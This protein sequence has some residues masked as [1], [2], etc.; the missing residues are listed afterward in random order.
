MLS[1]SSRMCDSRRSDSM[2]GCLQAKRS[3]RRTGKFRK[4]LSMHTSIF[5]L[6]FT[7]FRSIGSR[8]WARPGLHHAI[9]P[10][11]TTVV[12]IRCI[13]FRLISIPQLEIV[14]S[15]LIGNTDRCKSFV[16]KENE[17]LETLSK[18]NFLSFQDSLRS[19]TW[20]VCTYKLCN[21]MLR[22]GCILKP[23]VKC[24]YHILPL[25][26][27]W[28]GSHWWRQRTLADIPFKL[29]LMIDFFLRK[30]T[31]SSTPGLSHGHGSIC[32]IAFNWLSTWSSGFQF[33]SQIDNYSTSSP[34]L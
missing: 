1:I 15:R 34:I 11:W 13:E 17:L 29:S 20:V 22:H 25:K 6:H 14:S 27:L 23:V 32:T 33:V 10:L 28:L 21:P 9:F 30:E 18:L 16:T 26:K 8:G 7:M 2:W 3:K 4:L 31:R 24:R 19:W 12:T 5:D